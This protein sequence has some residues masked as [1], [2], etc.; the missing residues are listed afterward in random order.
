MALALMD[1]PDTAREPERA[2]YT[3]AALHGTHDREGLLWVWGEHR[4][5]GFWPLREGRDDA[6]TLGTQV[7][8]RTHGSRPP[9]AVAL[10]DLTRAY[11]L[12]GLSRVERAVL[13]AYYVEALGGKW[14][15]RGEHD[16]YWRHVEA[17][18]REHGEMPRTVLSAGAAVNASAVGDGRVAERLKMN[19]RTA[20]DTRWR[21]VRK[22]CAYLNGGG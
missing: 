17:H 5:E 16:G 4:R 14:R 18:Y 12:A 22:M 11:D 13:H 21:A 8:A 9:L 2:R 7:R 20:C 3:P 10:M 19:R 1:E 15:D 6:A